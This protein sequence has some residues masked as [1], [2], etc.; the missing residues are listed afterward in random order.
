MNNVI[1]VIVCVG[2]FCSTNF[3]MHKEHTIINIPQINLYVER[4]SSPIFFQGIDKDGYVYDLDDSAINILKLSNRF[5]SGCLMQ[6]K[7]WKYCVQGRSDYAS[8]V[9]IRKGCGSG[10]VPLSLNSS[11]FFVPIDLTEAQV[12]R[13]AQLRKANKTVF[14]TDQY[15][16]R[17]DIES[18]SFDAQG[19]FGQ[20]NVDFDKRQEAE[21]LQQQRAQEKR[22]DGR[23]CGKC[24]GVCACCCGCMN[25][26]MV[27]LLFGE[28]LFFYIH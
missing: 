20:L 10:D 5:K 21:K 6:S 26:M 15:N 4:G 12:E 9:A 11:D 19:L 25:I 8:S 2:L 7:H 23:R 3:G 1:K 18:L 28:A 13:V 27:M 17:L 14:V 24:V 22:D 16:S